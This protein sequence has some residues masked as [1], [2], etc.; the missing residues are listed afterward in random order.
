METP[1]GQPPALDWRADGVPL[2]PAFDDAYFGSANALHEIAHVFL[3]GTGLWQKLVEA[4]ADVPLHIGETGFGTGLNFCAAVQLWLACKKAGV[5]VPPLHF[6]SVEAW[7]LTKPDM[8]KALAPFKDVAEIAHELIAAWP[9]SFAAGDLFSASFYDG[10]VQLAIKIDTAEAALLNITVPGGV[11]IW[12]LDGFAPDQNSAMWQAAVMREVGRLSAPDARLATFTAAGHVRRALEKA[13]FNVRRVK[14]FGRKRHMT[15]G[16]F[17]NTKIRPKAPACPQGHKG[18][19]ARI[20]II[21]GGLAG[22][23]LVER[24]HHYFPAARVTLFDEDFTGK[25]T[26]PI[27]SVVPRLDVGDA[28]HAWLMP[29]V[30]NFATDYWAGLAA[31]QGDENIF[32]QIGAHFHPVDAAAQKRAGQAVPS[33]GGELQADGSVFWPSAGVV[34]RA[35]AFA[36]MKAAANPVCETTRLKKLDAIADDFDHIIL[37]AGAGTAP[38]LPN[39]GFPA[40][41]R[42]GALCRFPCK[43][44]PQNILYGAGHVLPAGGQEVWTGASF[45]H[46]PLDGTAP[47]PD[48]FPEDEAQGL[49]RI[50]QFMGQPPTGAVMQKW[51]GL[52]VVTPDQLP[53]A[54]LLPNWT[55]LLESLAGLRH[56]QWLDQAAMQAAFK[57]QGRAQVHILAGLGARGFLW[58]PMMADRVIRSLG[59]LPLD[60]GEAVLQALAPW[61]FLLREERFSRLDRAVKLPTGPTL[62]LTG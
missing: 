46:W 21:G 48:D 4:P 9:Q 35:A 12:F 17:A 53:V 27:A 32:Q 14:G 2:A 20:A 58:A 36:A 24:A 22:H 23:V 29:R 38:F 47:Q 52:R 40:S 5:D 56:G 61:R 26:P 1:I 13:G 8:A 50:T 62:C 19:G 25:A 44:A 55:T 45:A 6:T 15:V 41:G 33:M 59:G 49:E 18:Q 31:R 43:E 39:L 42:A 3:N 28:A 16:E 10:Q 7:P 37:A 34:D 51:A 54:G 57:R 30:F 11:D 60:G